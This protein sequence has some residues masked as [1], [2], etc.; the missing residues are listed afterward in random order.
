ME[1]TIS[2]II[3][4]L[5]KL[6]I[7]QVHNLEGLKIL[8]LIVLH[9]III[10]YL[11]I[12]NNNLKPFLNQVF[13]SRTK[14]KINLLVIILL[15]KSKQIQTHSNHLTSFNL[16]K[17]SIIKIKTFLEEHKITNRIRTIRG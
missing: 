8:G 6:A 15:D 9:L 10:I 4:I 5:Q 3:S 11:V 17:I 1:L 13:L 7:N 16:L 12:I 2:K 14:I